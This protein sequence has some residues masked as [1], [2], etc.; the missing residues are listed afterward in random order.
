M[1]W[2][3][4]PRL[5]ITQLRALAHEASL[6][7]PDQPGIWSDL[8]GAFRQLGHHREAVDL[9]EKAVARMPDAAGLRLSLAQLDFALGRFDEALK[10]VRAA[11]QAEP[12]NPGARSLHVALLYQ[13]SQWD[14]L[15][16]LLDEIAELNPMEPYL[17]EAWAREAVKP[18][19]FRHLLKR[20]ETAL[21]RGQC[22][23][24]VYFKAF[25]LAKL[26]RDEEARST[27]STERFVEI[28]DLPT[29]EGFATAG[30][31]REALAEEVLRN[32]TLEP[33]PRGKATRGGRQ[34]RA[35]RQPDAPAVANLI[36]Q[37]KTAVD[38][39]DERLPSQSALARVRPTTARLDAWAVVYGAEGQQTPHRHPSSWVSG[40]YYVC[41]PRPPGESS[42]RGS[43]VLGVLPTPEA[44]IPPWG[45]RK[46]EPVPGRLVIFPSY[47][48]HST[49][50]TGIDG[51]RISVAFDVVPAG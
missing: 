39:Y 36:Q 21:A 37:I 48:P 27:L 6:A 51:A 14:E 30:S 16:P 5:K 40:V 23:N 26:G 8:G 35:L 34:T 31:F 18:E 33:D 24:A 7:A 12:E 49:M 38:D 11:L 25:A 15:K 46:I 4:E 10:H 20:C 43:L 45:E 47:V 50:S 41:A 44:I 32:P 22:T 19:D 9:M 29:P 2:Q 28:D 1:K 3:S 17:Y 13:T 42:Y